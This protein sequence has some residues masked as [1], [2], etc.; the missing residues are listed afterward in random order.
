VIATLPATLSPQRV[1]TSSAERFGQRG[2]RQP[3]RTITGTAK[4]V[5]IDHAA[6]RSQDAMRPPTGTRSATCES[7][8]PTPAASS[9]HRT[10]S[11]SRRRETASAS[12]TP[13]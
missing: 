10:T 8:W 1:R 11:G 5:K 12:R 3:S 6:P 9:D 4:I 13:M 7:S 2:A